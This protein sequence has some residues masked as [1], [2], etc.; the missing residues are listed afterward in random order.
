MAIPRNLANI[1]PHVAGSSGGITGLTFNATQSASAGANTLD[2][3]EEGT[4]TPGVGGDATYTGRYGKYT[5][6]G[7]V[8]TCQFRLKIATLGTGTQG[9]FSGFPFTSSTEGQSGH[10]SYYQDLGANVIYLSFYVSSN[11]TSATFVSQ[12][13]SGPTTTNGTSVWATGADIY[14]HVIY[15]VD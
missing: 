7:N 2:D 3:Y 14:G 13:A 11:S 12:S 1:A 5:K 8:V 6:I 15:R 4:W 10:C 9:G